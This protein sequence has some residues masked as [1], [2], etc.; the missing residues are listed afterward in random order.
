MLHLFSAREELLRYGQEHYRPH[1][2]ESSTLLYQLL[3]V[4]C[5]DNTMS[6]KLKEFVRQS[7]DELLRS[8]PPEERLK[9]L[10]AEELRTALP[11]EER[12]KGLSV[13]E[14]IRAIPPGTL[15]ALTRQLKGNDSS[16]K[17]E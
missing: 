2:Q 17:P 16:P 5:E 7:I 10:P 4:Y 15:E 8:L 6:E 9:G 1:S 3:R 14:M 13:E 11:V 12:L